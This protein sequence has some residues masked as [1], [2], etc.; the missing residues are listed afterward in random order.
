MIVRHATAEWQ[1]NIMEG[2]GSISTESKVM[3]QTPYSFN[4]RFEG[5]K[6]TNPEEL[7]AAAHAGCFSMAFAAELQKQGLKPDKI[8]SRA[9][10]SL[11]KTPEGFSIPAIHLMVSAKVPEAE[12]AKLEKI[13]ETAKTNCPVSKLMKAKIRMDL[14]IEG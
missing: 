2:K 4:T 11:E 8:Q 7:I 13:A 9:E 10:V 6:G 3:N 12:K 14:K 5:E 1:G